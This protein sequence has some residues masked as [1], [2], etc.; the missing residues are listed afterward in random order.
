MI[1]FDNVTFTYAGTEA[2]AL[3]S[4]SLHVAPGECVLVTG[5]SGCGKTTLLHVACGLAPHS[6]QGTLSGHV[7]V[8]GADPAQVPL[9]DQAGR[10]CLVSQNPQTQFYTTDSTSEVAFSL[11]NQGMPPERIIERIEESVFALGAEKLMDRSLFA[12]SGGEK[13]KVACVCTDAADAS[14]VLLD[15]ATANLDFGTTIEL[16]GIV[17]K[18]KERGKAILIADHRIAWAL[19]LVTRVVMMEESEIARILERDELDSIDEAFCQAHG[20]RSPTFESAQS[21]DVARFAPRSSE[22]AAHAGKDRFTLE[23]LHFANGACRLDFDRIDIARGKITA[24]V[25]ENGRGKSTFLRCLAGLERRDQSTLVTPDGDTLA[26]RQRLKRVFLIWQDV[27]CQLFTQSVQEEVELSL[28]KDIDAA[29]VGDILDQ[30]DLG[31]FAEQ[32]PFTLSGG[33]KQRV[34]VACAIASQRDVLLLDEPT[35]GL[36]L[37]H[38]MQMSGLLRR[39]AENGTTI[40]VVTHDREFVQTVADYLLVL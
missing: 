8:G 13:Q 17:G 3:K 5:P 21:V 36:D 40:V 19:G 23:N 20:L 16:A 14:V 12:L 7:E 34:A 37:H 35:S 22:G 25:G 31:A 33:Q 2:P 28:P 15:E 32:D 18:W 10:T 27:N 1:R 38:M 4:V 39:L 24:V 9:Y 30:L 11:E 29:H 6:F 26:R